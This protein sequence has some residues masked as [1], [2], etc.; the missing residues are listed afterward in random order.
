MN[1]A[2]PQARP[3]FLAM[4]ALTVES[5]FRISGAP[6]MLLIGNV[7]SFKLAATQLAPNQ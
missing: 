7:L 1:K 2:A 6:A 5:F 4:S 3:L